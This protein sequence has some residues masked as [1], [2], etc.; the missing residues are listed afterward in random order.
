MVCLLQ[1]LKWTLHFYKLVEQSINP[2][3]HVLKD[4]DLSTKCKIISEAEKGIT[5][6][7]L[8]ATYGIGQ[9]TVSSILKKKEIYIERFNCGSVST[10][11]K[12]EKLSRFH[13]DIFTNI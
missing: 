2:G 11:T 4:L 6:S 8:A 10:Q 7:K 13:L 3:R 5:Q 9:A 12:R 1:L